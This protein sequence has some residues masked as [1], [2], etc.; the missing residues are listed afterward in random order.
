MSDDELSDNYN[1]DDDEGSIG[2]DPVTKSKPNTKIKINNPI[3]TKI[4]G[5]GEATKESDD[6]SDDEDDDDDDDNEDVVVEKDSDDDD[7]DDDDDI[8]DDNHE[9]KEVANTTNRTIAPQ[10]FIQDAYD[11]D[12]NDDDDDDDD[13]QYLQKFNS[14]IIKS[15]ISNFH[16][17]NIQHN[18]EEIMQLYVVTRNE[19]GIIIDPLHKTIPHLTKYERTRILGQR[20]KQIESGSNPFI[21]VPEHVIDSYIIAELELKA[22]KIPFIIRRPIP[23]GGCEYW[24]LDDLEIIDF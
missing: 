11:D 7:D 15:H 20:S 1:T 13:E 3:N 4:L 8:E 24:N 16:P 2:S 12:D 17:E 22:K 10:H 9:M 5:I 18:Y 6:D 19:D 23:N 14:E 21:K